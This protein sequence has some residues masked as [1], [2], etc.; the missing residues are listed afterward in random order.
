MPPNTYSTL[1]N[2]Y[3]DYTN[4]IDHNVPSDYKAQVMSLMG[5]MRAY[6]VDWKPDRAWFVV[7]QS[8]QLFVTHIPFDQEYYDATM[9]KADTFYRTRL[10]VAFVRQYNSQD[11]EPL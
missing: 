11:Q 10:L 9:I 5:Y 7:W 1:G 6:H 3:D 8:T 4:T 2:R